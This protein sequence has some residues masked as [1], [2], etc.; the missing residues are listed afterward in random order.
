MRRVMLL[1]LALV[2]ALGGLGIGYAAWTD[3]VAFSGTV[4]TGEVDIDLTGEYSG[5]YVYKDLEPDSPTYEER[6][7]V[8]TETDAAGV[9]TYTVIEPA[10][11]GVIASIPPL[12]ELI[13]SAQASGPGVGTDDDAVTVIF[14]DL[15]PCIDF[16]ADFKVHV[17]GTVPVKLALL[18]LEGEVGYYTPSVAGDPDLDDV[19]INPPDNDI[20]AI[21]VV[22]WD[23]VGEEWLDI[24]GVQFEYC[25][26]IWVGIIVH[27]PQDNDFML[28]SGA[29]AGRIVAVQWDK[30]DE[31]P[32]IWDLDDDS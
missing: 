16:I 30:Y 1:S 17:Y 32:T 15:Y 23:E 31:G 27:I 22:Y 10:G 8:R 14:E 28:T 5:T 7:I 29:I 2:V 25:N 12:W 18:P 26:E 11:I 4:T 20:P 9:V 24:E 3:T 19:F 6:I 13:A 21:R